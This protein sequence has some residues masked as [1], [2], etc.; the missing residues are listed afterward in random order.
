[1]R[2]YTH[3]KTAERGVLMVI[4]TVRPGDSINSIARRYGLSEQRII[5][6]NELRDP[7][8]LVVGQTLVLTQ[9][10]AVYTVAQGDSVYSIAARFGITPNEL[11]RNNPQ[12]GG[13]SE[14]TPGQ[15]LVIALPPKAFGNIDTNGYAYPNIDRDVLRK[16]L[17]YLTYLTL[18]TY[19]FRPDGTLIGIEDDELISLARSYGVAPIMLV[20][21]LGEDGTFSNELA[22]TLLA[23]PALQARLIANIAQTLRQK[24]Y[25]GVD[26]DFEYVP[27]EY[28]DEYVQFITD[29][30]AALAPDGY[31]VFVA[32]APKTSADQP[33]LLYEGHDYGGLGEAAD[34]VLL[35]T[36]EW[37]YT[38]GPAYVQN[39]PSYI[40]VSNPRRPLHIVLL[41]PAWNT[42][43]QKASEFPLSKPLYGCPDRPPFSAKSC[44]I[45]VWSVQPDPGMFAGWPVSSRAAPTARKR[46]FP[47]VSACEA[48]L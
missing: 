2:A 25:S 29:L 12:L 20:S 41:F 30:R 47:S 21:T 38:Y 3:K 18:F 5:E 45:Y 34:G 40:V 43:P 13:K 24:N 32:L 31:K 17:P 37:G 10:T 26:I 44:R 28:A 8:A 11:W 6:E 1:M 7:N 33:G 35:M 23:D 19:G 39:F 42:A 48:R 15:E 36:Y 14:L 4:Y 22:A 27:G 46:G 9:P 16:T